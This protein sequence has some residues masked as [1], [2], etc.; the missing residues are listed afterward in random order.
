[1]NKVIPFDKLTSCDLDVDATYEGGIRGNTGDDPI[2]RLVGGG[3][4]GGFRYVGS[5]RDRTLKLSVCFYHL[6]RAAHF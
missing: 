3:N 5:P 1:M 2:N 4:Q 6:K